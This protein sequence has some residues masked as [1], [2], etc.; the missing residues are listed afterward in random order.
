MSCATFTLLFKPKKIIEN[1][2]LNTKDKG[3]LF[4]YKNTKITWSNECWDI[5]DVN[6][7]EHYQVENIDNAILLIF[8]LNGMLIPK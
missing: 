2:L 6:H 3:G 1:E 8:G 4:E 5:H 7:N